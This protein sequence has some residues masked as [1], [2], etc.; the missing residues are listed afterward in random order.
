[1]EV[2][3]RTLARLLA[4]SVVAT[5]ASVPAVLLAETSQT[6]ADSDDDQKMAAEQ[7]RASA[8]QLDKVKLPMAT[9]PAFHFKA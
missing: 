3:R 1:L 2:T 4:S 9:E 5:G 6:A 8:Q 7:M